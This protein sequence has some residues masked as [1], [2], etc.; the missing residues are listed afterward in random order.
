MIGEE[1]L[2]VE[3]WRPKTVEECILPEETKKIFLDVVKNG[4]VPNFLFTGTPGTGKTTIA[5][6]IA[7]ELGLDYM[8]INCSMNGGIDTLR[9]DIQK[10]ASS[11]SI[12]GSGRKLVILDEADYLNPNSTQPAL[13]N[14]MEEFSKNCAFV[15]TCNYVNRIIEPLRSRCSLVEFKIAKADRPKL[16]KLF[17]QRVL[18]ILDTEGVEYDKK[19]VAE[20]I[21]KNIPDWRKVLNELQKYSVSG[22]IDNQILS[23]LTDESFNKLISFMKDKNYTEVRKWVSE[24]Q[25]MDGTVLFRKLYDSA[26]DLLQPV[27]IP[28]LVVTIGKYQYTQAFVADA[29]INTAACLAE[30]IADAAWK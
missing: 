24:H 14:F 22:K 12:T 30:I 15:L 10:F 3:K 8:V 6:A 4:K 13:R 27:S 5:K 26:S 21:N 11:L 16:A 2:W 23:N 20:L 7:N 17:F 25:D 9:Q 19:V 28:L 1:Y 29:E 18:N